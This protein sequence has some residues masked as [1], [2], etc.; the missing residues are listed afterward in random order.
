MQ[1]PQTELQ[2]GIPVGGGGICQPYGNISISSLAQKMCKY[3]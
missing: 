2:T 1:L 3:A